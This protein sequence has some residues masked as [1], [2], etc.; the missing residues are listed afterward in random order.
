[1]TERWVSPDGGEGG[2]GK[3]EVGGT[4][5]RK[6]KHFLTA[7]LLMKKN[8][9]EKTEGKVECR[10]SLPESS[11]VV[12]GGHEKLE[13]EKKEYEIPQVAGDF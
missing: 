7:I 8:W 5:W 6:K 13:R 12:H 4:P 2:V 11:G 3:K 1:L 10:G 9:S